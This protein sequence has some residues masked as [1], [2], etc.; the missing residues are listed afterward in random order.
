[1]IT[2]HCMRASDKDY[3]HSKRKW[4]GALYA[5]QI[6]SATM[7]DVSIRWID[8]TLEYGLFA[9]KDMIAWEFIG[10]YTGVVRRH[11][12]IFNKINDYCFLYPTSRYFFGK[13]FIDG[14][15]CGNEIRYANHSDRPNSESTG[16]FSDGMFHMI[17]RAIKDIPA[18]A[19][20]TYDYG[21]RYWKNRPRIPNLR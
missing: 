5:E 20:I 10:E 1:R 7:A 8:D 13:Y 15:K 16:I 6:R 11:Y 9:E 18:G 17:L 2:K 21:D 4:L 14:E 12:P 19:Q 3:I